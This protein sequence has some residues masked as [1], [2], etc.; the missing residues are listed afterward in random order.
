[1]LSA[2]SAWEETM[3]YPAM[4]GTWSDDDLDNL[5]ETQEEHE[6][7]LLGEDADEKVYG[8]LAD[9][10]EACNIRSVRDFTFRAK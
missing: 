10:E 9:L 6:K 4:N 2:H 8:M 5:K 1:M 7:K 3:L